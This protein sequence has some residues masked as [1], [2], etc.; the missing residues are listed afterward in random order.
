MFGAFLFGIYPPSGYIANTKLP[1]CGRVGDFKKNKTNGRQPLADHNLTNKNMPLK[2]DK[3]KIP[4]E[5]D[6]RKKITDDDRKEAKEL[7]E[8]GLAIREIARRMSHISRRSIVFILFPERLVAQ[9]E[10]QKKE[11]HWRRYYD[12][13]RQKQAIKKLREKKRKIFNIPQVRFKRAKNHQ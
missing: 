10:K 1:R 11:E 4:K 2:F 9:Q 6:G 13:N 7:Y 3:F 8:R 5:L 12:K